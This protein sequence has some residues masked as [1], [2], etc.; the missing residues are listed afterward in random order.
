MD[1]YFRRLGSADST[2]RDRE[3]TGKEVVED[4]GG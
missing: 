2:G 4:A 1:V 3:G